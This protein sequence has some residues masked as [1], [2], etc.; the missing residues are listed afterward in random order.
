MFDLLFT[1]I[2]FS[3]YIKARHLFHLSETEANGFS[4]NGYFVCL[5]GTKRTGPLQMSIDDE[6]G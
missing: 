3:Q 5:D 4:T 2:A 6:E 1:S